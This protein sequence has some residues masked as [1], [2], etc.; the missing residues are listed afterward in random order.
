MER[1]IIDP[2]TLQVLVR[3]AKALE[4]IALAVEYLE[5]RPDLRLGERKE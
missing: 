1:V 3:I 4:R 5:Q 2:Q